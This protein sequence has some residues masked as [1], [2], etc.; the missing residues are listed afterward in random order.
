MK[1]YEDKEFVE[2]K[3]IRSECVE[4]HCDMC[5]RKAEYPYNKGAMFE[6]GAVGTG[7]GDL[8]SYYYIDGDYEHQHLDLCEECSSWLVS[9][10]ESGLIKR[11]TR[12]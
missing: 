12:G 2:R 1:R 6:W 10:I 5:K 9:G 3:V 7:G 11:P 8:E 4:A